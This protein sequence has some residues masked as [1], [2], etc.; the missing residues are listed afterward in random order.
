MT[1]NEVDEIL[2][3]GSMRLC[4]KWH[5]VNMTKPD[6]ADRGT[7]RGARIWTAG[8]PLTQVLLSASL[9]LPG[10]SSLRYWLVASPYLSML[11]ASSSSFRR[12]RSFPLGVFSFLSWLTRTVYG[13]VR[14]LF[15]RD[16]SFAR[17][18]VGFFG[19]PNHP[20]L[21]QAHSRPGAFFLI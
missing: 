13:P 16:C 12:L 1:D 2:E 20:V 5:T 19:A 9:M 21:L 15:A 10:S 8:L 17:L 11:L 14:P 4:W 18:T 6:V 7:L 3:A